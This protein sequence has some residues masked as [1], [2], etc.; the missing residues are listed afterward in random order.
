MVGGEMGRKCVKWKWNWT[1]STKERKWGA[2][3]LERLSHTPAQSYCVVEGHNSS[4][5]LL[6]LPNHRHF[7]N[8][9]PL[10]LPQPHPLLSSI[11]TAPPWARQ[12]DPA[13]LWHNHFISL[14]TGTAAWANS[15]CVIRSPPPQGPQWPKWQPQMLMILC[16]ETTPSS[17]TPSCRGS[18]TSLWSQRQVSLTATEAFRFELCFDC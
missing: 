1:K 13:G 9:P 15:H 16:L 3:G 6:H 4:P 2:I 8:I 17:S 10:T 14:S 5:R 11:S 7:V 18:P 12:T